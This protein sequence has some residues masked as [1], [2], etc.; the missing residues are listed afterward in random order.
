MTFLLAQLGSVTDI[1]S[2]VIALLA[3]ALAIH[4]M[5]ATR[6]HN[7]LSL[8]PMLRFDVHLSPDY[9]NAEL[10]LQNNGV[11]PAILDQ[12]VMRLDGQT[13]KEAG[14]ARV[15]Q[16]TERLGWGTVTSYDFLSAGDVIKTDETRHLL[17]FPLGEFKPERTK[18]IR[19]GLRRLSFVVEYRSLYE[20]PFVVSWS[21]K[22]VYGEKE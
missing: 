22:E 20:E 3:F 5:H 19:D 12:V 16:L 13:P 7:K 21:G 17:R 6:R 15:E 14:I 10:L 1:A 8:R 9:P 11:G 18:A 4:E 2:V